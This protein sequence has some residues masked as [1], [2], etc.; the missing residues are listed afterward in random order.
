MAWSAGMVVLAVGHVTW[1]VVRQLYHAHI[2]TAIRLHVGLACVNLLIASILGTL[3]GTDREVDVVPGFVITNVYAHAH[4]AG[5][6]WATLMVVGVGHRLLPMVLPSAM[7]EGPRTLVSVGL[8]ELGVVG[9][10][11]SLLV[12]GQA[13]LVWALLALG[14]IATFLTSVLWMRRHR[15]PA[16]PARP[17][18]DWGAG[19]AGQSLLYL[20]AASGIGVFL[21][22]SPVAAW[23]ARLSMLYG[24]LA[25]VGFLSQIVVGME[26][27]IL[28]LFQWHTL[29]EASGRT[30]RP[31]SPHTLGSQTTRAIIFCAWT[32]GVPL[33]AA[34]LTLERA[35]LVG[36]GGWAL[37]TAMVLHSVNTARTLMTRSAR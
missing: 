9:L 19:H 23:T 33:L 7:P 14:G 21:V 11:L 18:P 8:I 25:L 5:L 31:P 30:D 27:R 4:M 17:T 20:L 12:T 13:G 3:L 26:H 15:R 29:F 35:L 37:L 34:G 32:L 2:P 1:R 16:P 36:L 28:P 10:F 6:G 24:V 22:V